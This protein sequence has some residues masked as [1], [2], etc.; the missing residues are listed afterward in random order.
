MGGIG[1]GGFMDGD[2]WGGGL[3]RGGWGVALDE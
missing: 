1:L 2:F 3:G